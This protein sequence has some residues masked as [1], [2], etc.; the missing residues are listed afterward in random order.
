MG[1]FLMARDLASE[2]EWEIRFKEYKKSGLSINAWCTQ[3]GFKGSTFHYWVKKFKAQE[4][5]APAVKAQFAEVILEC[6]NTTNK[7]ESRKLFL[8]YGSF[9]IDIVDSFNPDTLTE[10]LK[11]LKSL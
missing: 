5:I 4:Q 2:K 8:S 7:V 10:L 1:G 11:V 6:C 3:N 9:T